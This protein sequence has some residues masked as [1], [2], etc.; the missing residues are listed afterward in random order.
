VEAKLPGN[1]KAAIALPP[2]ERKKLIAARRKTLALAKEAKLG[3][4]RI[5]R[6]KNS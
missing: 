1:V 6:K 2:A 3:S 4:K 5:Q